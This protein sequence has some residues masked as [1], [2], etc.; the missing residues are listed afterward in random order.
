M[1]AGTKRQ[2]PWQLRMLRGGVSVARRKRQSNERK[3][4]T[5]IG[6]LKSQLD[7]ELLEDM[8]PWEWPQNARD[9]FRRTLLDEAAPGNDRLIA[10]R[11]AGDFVVINDELSEALLG[12][13][14]SA[15]QLEEIRAT[16]AISLGPVLEHADTSGFD[17]PDDTPITEQTFHRIQLTLQKTYAEETVPVLVRRRILEAS[18][19]S[20]Q[21]WHRDAI[22]QAHST[23][24]RDW[25]LT[26]VFA[27]RWVEGFDEFIVN[28]V[29]STDL[30]IQC[31]AI[32]AA[33]NWGIDAAMDRILPLVGDPVTPKFLRLAAIEAAA[34]IR[35]E[36]AHDFLDDLV[37][38]EDEDIAEV[39]QEALLFADLGEDADEFDDEDEDEEF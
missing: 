33:G 34:E 10:A 35:P 39:A 29:K 6:P 18:V 1:R 25:I 14:T 4:G 32:R 28:S 24:E 38:S 37:D 27:M 13:V 9:I 31:E 2:G 36:E 20:P 30:D 12:I 8:P 7:L 3:S 23:G 21:D 17:D 16:A 26:A 22:S 11:L 5:G 19:R 15:N